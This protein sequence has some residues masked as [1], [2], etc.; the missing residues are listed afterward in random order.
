MKISELPKGTVVE[1]T[2]ADGE[3]AQYELSSSKDNNP[4]YDTDYISRDAIDTIDERRIK[5]ISVP[6]E[7]TLMLAT[8]L[9]NVYT[10]SGTPESL[11]V[12]AAEEAAKTKHDT[13]IAA[14][15]KKDI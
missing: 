7:V 14:Q 10:K 3:T 11:I 2:Y 1:V 9:D 8:W 5:I 13:H 6:Y 15:P 12:E 4:N